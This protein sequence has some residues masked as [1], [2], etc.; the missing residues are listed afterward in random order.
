MTSAHT[1]KNHDRDIIKKNPSICP[2]ILT[3][4]I[5]AS[6]T[7][8][9]SLCQFAWRIQVELTFQRQVGVNCARET[10]VSSKSAAACLKSPATKLDP[11]GT[12]HYTTGLC[13]VV[14]RSWTLKEYGHAVLNT[15][16]LF[17]NICII[18]P[19]VLNFISDNIGFVI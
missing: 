9:G 10:C 4:V 11:F 5:Q 16:V 19:R 18:R 2:R 13:V 1:C 17:I 12:L 15:S 3:P 14:A 7:T 6:S 8:A